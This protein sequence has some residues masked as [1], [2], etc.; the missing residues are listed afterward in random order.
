MKSTPTR[1]KI[2]FFDIDDTLYIKDTNHVPSS[3]APAL[4]ALKSAGVIVAIASGRS[5]GVIPP[6][7]RALIDEVGIDLLL[8]IN[9]GYN[10]WQGKPFLDFPLSADTAY[11]I[12][13]MLNADNIGF[14]CMSHDRIYAMRDTANLRTALA[15]LHIPYQ[16]VS[17]DD[18]DFN[19]PIYQIL[20]FYADGEYNPTLPANIKTVRWHRC[21]VDILECDG[22]KARAIAQVLDRLGIHTK[23]ACAFGDGLNDIE[24]LKLVGTAIAM[25]N[26]HPELKPFADIVCPRHDEDG[27]AKI[28]DELGWIGTVKNKA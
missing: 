26:A 17:L 15:S 13:Q 9:G 11:H 8:T 12:T 22:S 19:Q 21:A 2:I 20:A 18:F 1:P 27:I 5:I 10:L 16:F 24:M 6:V 28:L 25:D 14:A 7:V 3:V 23:D 4:K